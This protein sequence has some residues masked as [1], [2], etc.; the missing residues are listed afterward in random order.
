MTLPVAGYP[1]EPTGVPAPHRMQGTARL[2]L[3]LGLLALGVWTIHNF[4]PALVWA[5]ILA[6]AVWPLYRRLRRRNPK[7][8]PV[9]LPAV[10]TLAT[11]IALGLPFLV[12]AVEAGREGHDLLLLVQHFTQE[13]IAVPDWVDHL[14]FGSAQV[15]AWWKDNLSVPVPA[16]DILRRVNRGSVLVIG[17]QFGAEIAHRMVIFFF[18][19]MTLFFLLRSGESLIRDLLHASHTLFGTRGERVARQMVSSI[20]GTVD[21]LV[22]VGIGEGILMGIAYKIAGVPHPTLL[23]GLT[24][25]AAMIPFAVFIVFIGIGAL[26]LAQGAL[27]TAIVIVVLG[28]TVV[29]LADHLIRPVLIGGATRL[30]FLW[31]LLGILGGVETWGIVGLFV[32]PALM[33]AL[34]LL[35][36]EFTS[37]AREAEGQAPSTSTSSAVLKG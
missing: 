37:G 4:L 31:V 36:R 5:S 21:G 17:R 20:H 11:A 24:A 34:I 8:D 2:A 3:V 14:P 6:I 18:M 15:S 10:F 26:L 30:P 29:T 25:I 22:L 28:T 16:A 23:G 1:P 32:G 19:L 7:P 35:W 13:G 12:L 9:L 33:A 27:G